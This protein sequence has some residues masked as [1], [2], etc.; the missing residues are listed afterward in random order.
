MARFTWWLAAALLLAACAPAAVPP[1]AEEPQPEINLDAVPPV[2]RSRHIVPLEMII[3]DTFRPVDRAVPLT[4]IDPG[5]LRRLRDA[6]PPIYAPRFERA[7]AGDAWLKPHD[8]VL[9]YA[10][11]EAAYAYPVRILNYHEMVL[12]DDGGR[13]LLA[14]Y[15]PLCRS[16]IVYDRRLA[17][18]AGPLLFGNTSALYESDM[19]MFDHETGSYWMQVSGQALVGELA[20]ARLTPL[21]SQTT[22]WRQWRAQFPDTLVLSRETGHSR[23][24]DRDPFLGLGE[25]LTQ[26]GQFA[27]PV[28]EKGRDP[29][30]D[31]G[32]IVL[33]VEVDGRQWAYPL[34]RLGDAVVHDWI[35]DGDSI[36]VVIFSAAEGPAG[37]AFSPSL[38]SRRLTFARRDGRIVDEE[39]GSEWN[40]AG[41]AVAGELVGAQLTA[42]PTRSTFWFSQISAFPDLELVW[43]LP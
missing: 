43:P 7:A 23:N 14:T 22:T 17:G 34:G 8:L 18:R 6:I 12:H 9:G 25:R 40:L 38:D 29:R 41:R 11:E 26:S 32:E 16:G 33:G 35:G 39:T 30:L 1:P 20:G 19:V 10:G 15:C 31:P 37:G 36:A 3:F 13:P 28:S 4:E 2:D 42:F 21:P 24:Y 5:L 27:F